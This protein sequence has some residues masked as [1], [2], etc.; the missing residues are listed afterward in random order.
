MSEDQPQ[1]IDKKLS[2]DERTWVM[3][4]HF[5]AY[6]GCVFLPFGHILAPLIIWLRKREDYTLVAD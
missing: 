3:I 6:A 5:S 4:S 1:K 2:K